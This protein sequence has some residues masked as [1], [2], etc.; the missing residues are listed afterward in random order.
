MGWYNPTMTLSKPPLLVPSNS[1]V[2]RSKKVTE[3]RRN[4]PLIGRKQEKLVGIHFVGRKGMLRLKEKEKK[5]SQG[6]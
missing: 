1:W 3:C 5:P 6:I 2:L 4:Y